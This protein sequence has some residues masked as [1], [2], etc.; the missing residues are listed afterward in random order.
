MSRHAWENW[1]PTEEIREV[2]LEGG[3]RLRSAWESDQKDRKHYPISTDWAL[4]EIQ[5]MVST[6]GDRARRKEVSSFFKK[7]KTL[8]QL[9]PESTVK[10]IWED[11]NRGRFEDALEAASLGYKD[12]K[13]GWRVF[14]SIVVAIERAYLFEQWGWEVLPK[15]KASILH[16]GLQKIAIAAGLRDLTEAGFAEFLDDLCPCGISRHREAVRKF[17][18][19]SRQGAGAKHPRHQL[20]NKSVQD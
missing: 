10:A 3:K 7:P 11:H 13:K 14:K 5:S 1:V 19:R 12:P 9:I 4:A 8:S 2:L 15:P 18:T 17:R 6:S 16:K 20:P